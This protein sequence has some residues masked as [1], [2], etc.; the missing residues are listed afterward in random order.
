VIEGA[1][2]EDDR[3]LE[4]AVG[5]DVGK[6]ARHGKLRDGSFAGTCQ[7]T[8]RWRRR[9]RAADGREAV[10]SSVSGLIRHRASSVIAH[11]RG[12]AATLLFQAGVDVG[13]TDLLAII[14]NEA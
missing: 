8:T 6:E 13:V 7:D 14:P 4:E 11:H 2:G 12:Q 1:V 3:I 5:V 9:L 10:E